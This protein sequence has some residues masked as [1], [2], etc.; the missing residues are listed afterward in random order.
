MNKQ[1][2]TQVFNQI[3]GCRVVEEKEHAETSWF[4]V[5]I[6]YEDGKHHL[7]K[8]LEEKGVQ[9]RNYFA[10]NILMHPAYKHLDDPKNYPNS[11]KVLDNVF[12]L[13]CSPVITVDM[14]DYIDDM[15][16]DYLTEKK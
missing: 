4:G 10:G 14:L 3:P 6:I 9:T 15:V 2:L 1:A 8:Y 16:K 11:C 13:G 5:P 7:V 12:F